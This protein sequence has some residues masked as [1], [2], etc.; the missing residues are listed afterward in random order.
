MDEASRILS[1]PTIAVV[2][3]NV[4]GSIRDAAED[5]LGVTVQSIR[6]SDPDDVRTL[7]ID[8]TWS[9]QELEQ[10][11]DGTGRLE[12]LVAAGL[13]LER[14]GVGIRSLVTRSVVPPRASISIGAGGTRPHRRR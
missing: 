7:L 13:D 4:V 9:S 8:L 3:G 2:D 14:E 10:D 6:R 1:R 12:E 5:M 11:G